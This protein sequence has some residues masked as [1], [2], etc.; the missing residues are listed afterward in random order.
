[1]ASQEQIAAALRNADKAGDVQ[2]ARRLAQAYKAA[3]PSG[4]EMYD[5]LPGARPYTTG[6]AVARGAGQV[7]RGAVSGV[8]G[9]A[10]MAINALSSRGG[11][12]EPPKSSPDFD[13][14]QPLGRAAGTGLDRL[15]ITNAETPGEHYLQAAGA[16][17]VPMGG[18]LR[19]AV[20]GVLG[21]LT[22]E[23]ARQAGLPGW[24]QVGSG[25]LV[26]AGVNTVGAL[27]AP[28][29][30]AQDIDMLLAN[31]DRTVRMGTDEAVQNNLRRQYNVVQ[32]RYHPE[33]A[34]LDDAHPTFQPPPAVNP[35]EWGMPLATDRQRVPMS[36]V[37]FRNMVA[38]EN[39]AIIAEG[40]EGVL[41]KVN[42]M[43]RSSISGMEQ[44]RSV[45]SDAANRAAAT[46]PA[47]ARVLRNLRDAMGDDIDVT[48]EGS[49][50]ASLRARYKADVLDVYG[51]TRRGFRADQAPGEA[52]ETIRK[53]GATPNGR[54]E[55]RNLIAASDERTQGAMQ[56]RIVRE[57]IS[58]EDGEGGA[59]FRALT[60][61]GMGGWFDRDVWRGF[62][63]LMEANKKASSPIKRAAGEVVATGT[64]MVLGN[65]VGG[66]VGYGAAKGFERFATSNRG[67]LFLARM[68]RLPEKLT[69]QQTSQ[70]LVELS[71]LQAGQQMMV[72]DDQWPSE[73]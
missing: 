25:L 62:G 58:N 40:T 30:D 71:A 54:R 41:S 12:D 44:A 65:T 56:R 46:E 48:L 18:G 47:R 19:G 59:S 66:V 21:S 9:M 11:Y 43:D 35:V 15:G 31:R 2:A 72:R 8:A 61:A 33:Y 26:G 3:A 6:Q 63:R 73:Q 10:D 45:L 1:M 7:F 34:G 55:L 60:K 51:K 14:I 68:G 37:N 24:A 32:N 17:A 20:S 29:A 57:L 5:T 67:R 42:R 13:F 22:S 27:T 16:G 23:T 50:A 28:R 36:T 64:G 69:A 52:F 53:V 4:T 70:M 39:T 49:V 38:D